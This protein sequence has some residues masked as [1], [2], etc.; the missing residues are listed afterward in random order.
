MIHRLKSTFPNVAAI[1]Q[2]NFKYKESFFFKRKT[3]ILV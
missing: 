2:M 3:D 1:D